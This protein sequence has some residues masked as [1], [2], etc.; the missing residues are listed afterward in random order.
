MAQNNFFRPGGKKPSLFRSTPSDTTVLYT[1]YIISMS[2][3][4]YTAVEDLPRVIAAGRVL[5]NQRA[6]VEFAEEKIFFSIKREREKERNRKDVRGFL[7]TRIFQSCAIEIS[8][9]YLENAF[10]DLYMRSVSG[11]FFLLFF[12]F[13]F[14]YAPWEFNIDS[15]SFCTGTV[16][17]FVASQEKCHLI[18]YTY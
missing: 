13:F 8:V 16:R 9:D 3:A 6:N 4:M 5:V 15:R 14:L 10:F 17:S 18:C 7:S 11:I 12:A 1:R 2:I